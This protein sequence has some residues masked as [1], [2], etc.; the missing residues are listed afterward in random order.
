MKIIT[1]QRKELDGER[2]Y[3]DSDSPYEHRDWWGV[4]ETEA[5]KLV[6]DRVWSN[7]YYSN[8]DHDYQTVRSL[9]NSMVNTAGVNWGDDDVYGYIMPGETV[10]EIGGEYKDTDGDIW[11]RVE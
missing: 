1:M 4:I 6:Y 9:W 8:S 2:V 10:P 3:V 11:V 7:N 5:E